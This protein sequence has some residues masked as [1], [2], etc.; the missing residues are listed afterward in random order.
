[1]KFFVCSSSLFFCIILIEKSLWQWQLKTHM[2]LQMIACLPVCELS[3]FWDVET[4]QVLLSRPTRK[5]SSLKWMSCF[6]RETKSTGLCTPLG[7]KT[8]THCESSCR[9]VHTRKTP[10]TTFRKASESNSKIICPRTLTLKPYMKTRN[11]TRK[12]TYWLVTQ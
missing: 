3:S 7:F 8:I 4:C 5:T 11:K 12:N 1:M 2:T 9:W 10:S 6:V